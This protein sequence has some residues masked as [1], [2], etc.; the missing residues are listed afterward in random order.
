MSPEPGESPRCADAAGSCSICGDVA[1]PRQVIA[2]HGDTATAR[3][4][5]GA[6]SAVAIDFVPGVRPGDVI[7]VHLGVAIVRRSEAP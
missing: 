7:L 5:R 4:A 2:V 1:E 3:D 6:E